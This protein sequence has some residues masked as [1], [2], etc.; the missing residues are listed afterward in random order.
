MH[1]EP[2]DKEDRLKR[3]KKKEARPYTRYLQ[4]GTAAASGVLLGLALPDLTNAEN[5]ID[6]AKCGVI[7]GAATLAHY[8]VN[9]LALDKGAPQTAIGSLLSGAASIVS[10]FVVGAG[11]F[12]ATYAGFTIDGTEQLRLGKHATAQSAWI[13]AET[14]AAREASRVAP[15]IQA[16]A[17]EIA[18][19]ELCER[20]SSCLSGIGTGGAGLVFRTVSAESRRAEA[21]LD[22]VKAGEA[23]LAGALA[24]LRTQQAEFGRIVSD[25][26]LS[27]TERRVL[28]AESTGRMNLA[29]SA[30]AEA[31]PVA[32]A[33]GYAEALSQ[34]VPLLERP[35]AQEK[36]NRL[37][38]AHAVQIKAALNGVDDRTMAPPTF[39]SAAGVSDTFRYIPHFLPLA[40]LIAA[41]E[42]VLPLVIW[43]Y[44]FVALRARVE[45]E[46]PEEPVDLPPMAPGRGRGDQRRARR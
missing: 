19:T 2:E 38:A 40:L 8:G 36:L 27:R 29:A 28:A 1:R 39:P 33:R 17:A 23:R 4:P 42:F 15:I 35:Q 41:I 44:A 34:G 31:S 12:A 25:D 37:L 3:L 43:L 22:A 9:R 10:I 6:Y 30:L 24:D 7:A 26:S 16:T 5:L 18:A 20:E 11:M 14:R 13:D 46:D 21:M 32:M 45:E